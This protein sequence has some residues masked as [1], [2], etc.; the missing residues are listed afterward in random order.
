[1]YGSVP[2]LPL[3]DTDTLPPTEK[4]RVEAMRIAR[5]EMETITAQRRIKSALK[6][7]H[8][9]HPFPSFQFGV[10]VRVWREDEKKFVGPYVVHGY[11]NEKTVYVMKD[12]IRLFSASKVRLIPP[13]IEES[14]ETQLSSSADGT[15]AEESTSTRNL[16]GIGGEFPGVVSESE[17]FLATSNP[18]FDIVSN[19]FFSSSISKT[20]IHEFQERNASRIFLTVVVKNKSDPRFDKAKVQEVDQLIKL[21]TYKIVPESEISRGETILQSRFVLTIKNFKGDTEYFKARLV[22]LGI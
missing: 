20:A 15:T 13:E 21:G 5:K 8:K 22:I 7:R 10:K 9:I 4:S 2:R 14:A 18:V 11:D 6:Y 19:I 17:N 1:M 16:P 12:K 3:P